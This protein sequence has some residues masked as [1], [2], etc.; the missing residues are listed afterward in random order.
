MSDEEYDHRKRN[1]KHLEEKP[2]KKNNY[3]DDNGNESSRRHN[4]KS[5][6]L[7]MDDE[8]NRR[9]NNLLSREKPIS[10]RKFEFKERNDYDVSYK[11][12][13]HSYPDQ[14]RDVEMIKNNNNS[15]SSSSSYNQPRIRVK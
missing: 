10:N 6:N 13:K 14:F 15:T 12:K 8:I 7:E 3:D 11:E 5:I 2:F 9:I 4:R 1:L